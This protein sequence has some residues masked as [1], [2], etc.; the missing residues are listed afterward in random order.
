MVD[1]LDSSQRGTLMGNTCDSIWQVTIQAQSTDTDARGRST[2]AALRR[3]GFQHVT[4]VRASRIYQMR[5]CLHQADAQKL[6]AELFADP[7][8][9]EWDCTDQIGW[10]PESD[11]TPNSAIVQVHLQPA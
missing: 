1:A 9:E 4:A 3:A 5:G 11:L 6:A 8:V 7:V 2:L 10:P